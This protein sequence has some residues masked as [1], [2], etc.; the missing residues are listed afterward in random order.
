M[1]KS[2]CL[3]NFGEISQSTAE[4]LLLPVSETGRPPFWNSIT[5]FD[6]DICIVISMSFD[7]CLPN[8]VIIEQSVAEL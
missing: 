8:F 2:I 3:P 5:G 6:F 4:I 7:T 1:C